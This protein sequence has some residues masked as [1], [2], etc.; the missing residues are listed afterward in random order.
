MKPI[1]NVSYPPLMAVKKLSEQFSGVMP[2]R[3][4]G[5]GR[6]DKRK[7]EGPSLIAQ[8]INRILARGAQSGIER[9]D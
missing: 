1:G 9:A 5:F 2:L 6:M 4:W 7:A 3:H 8:R